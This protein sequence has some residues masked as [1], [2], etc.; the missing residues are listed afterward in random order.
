[1][2]NILDFPGHFEPRARVVT[3]EQNYRSTEPILAAANAVIGE[4]RERFAKDLWTERRSGA[5]PQL[6]T[7]RDETAQADYVCAEVLAARE[8]GIAAEGAGGAVPRRAATA[9]R[10]RSSSPGAT[11]RS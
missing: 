4:A 1:M 7:V 10:S 9:P 3:L 2:R 11:S 5:R 6:V 8:A